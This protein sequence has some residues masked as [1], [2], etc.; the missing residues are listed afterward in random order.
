MFDL[1]PFF[2]NSSSDNMNS[3]NN[4]NMNFFSSDIGFFNNLIDQI[5][6]SD[7]IEDIIEKVENATMEVQECDDGYVI[8]GDF[9]NMNKN[10][11]D[12][13]YREDN[14][15]IS[16]KKEDIS[17]QYISTSS[18]FSQMF[19]VPNVEENQIKAYFNKGRLVLC[20]PKKEIYRDDK[21]INVEFKCEEN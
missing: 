16:I 6:N 14:V 10:E 1:M 18:Q 5:M 9:P 12:I 21:Y 4:G 11:I 17:N 15:C 7:F 3:F 8:H 2:F 19:Y 13:D 20:L